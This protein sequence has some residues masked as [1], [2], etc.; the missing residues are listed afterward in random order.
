MTALASVRAPAELA[1]EPPARFRDLLAAEWIKLWS[2]R[3][4]PWSLLGAE[5]VVIAF[6]VGYAWDHYRYWPTFD[7]EHQAYFIAERMA[8][9]DAFTT[10]AGMVLMLCFSAIGAL[11]VVGEYGT[12]MI[13][14]T[15]AAVPAR[16]SVMAAK[17]LVVTAVTTV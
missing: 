1:V 8:L 16:R 3:S 13:R 10:N 7:R 4:T 5:L 9:W 17:L 12:G 11:T 15:F 2:L 6:N 14:T